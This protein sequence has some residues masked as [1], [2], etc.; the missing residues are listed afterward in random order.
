MDKLDNLDVVETRL[1]A[2]LPQ[3]PHPKIGDFAGN[4]NPMFHQNISRI[5]RWY[6]VRCSFTLR[7]IHADFAWQSRFHDNI[8]RDEQSFERCK[9]I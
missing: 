5:I 3:P 9:I 4:K 1:I 7:N 8:I 2:S 6:K